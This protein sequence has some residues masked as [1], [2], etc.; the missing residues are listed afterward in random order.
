MRYFRGP[1]NQPVN[2]FRR[3]TAPVYNKPVPWARL[4]HRLHL[5]TRPEWASPGFAAK[6]CV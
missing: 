3:T 2:D 6:H 1:D 4:A 5:A